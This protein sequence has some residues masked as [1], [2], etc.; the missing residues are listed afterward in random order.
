MCVFEK[1]ACSLVN[2]CTCFCV[3]AEAVVESDHEGSE[4]KTVLTDFA[5]D[6][7]EASA[8]EHKDWQ[9]EIAPRAL[10]CLHMT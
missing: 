2:A 5:G 7:T 4:S 10:L 3:K 1:R 9:A 6:G 8:A